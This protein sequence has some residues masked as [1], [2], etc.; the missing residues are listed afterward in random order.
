MK[1]ERAERL[2][3]ALRAN[4]KRRKAQ[5]RGASMPGAASALDDL[6]TDTGGSLGSPEGDSP[7]DSEHGGAG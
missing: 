3:A 2:A 7:T 6:G 4:L 1:D 5:A